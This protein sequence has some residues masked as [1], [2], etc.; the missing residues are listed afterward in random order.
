ML[1]VVGKIGVMTT[2]GLSDSGFT[3]GASPALFQTIGS[4]ALQARFWSGKLS[5]VFFIIGAVIFYLIL[6][7]SRLVPRFISIWGLVSAAALTVAN[8]AGVPDLTQSFEPAMLLYFPIVISE[9]LVAVW[10]I[11]KGFLDPEH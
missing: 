8:L 5:T 9:L 1:L 2:L 6:L 3:T 10:L 11:A 4:V 7:R